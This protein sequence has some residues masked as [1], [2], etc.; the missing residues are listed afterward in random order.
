VQNLAPVDDRLEYVLRAFSWRILAHTP[1]WDFE[2]VRGS[3]SSYDDWCAAWRRQ[4]AHHEAL[5]DEAAR[6]GRRLTAGEAYLRAALMCH[7][8]SFLFPHDQEQFGAALAEMERA[9]R[10]AAPTVDPP[11]ELVEVELD[12]VP[13]PG[14]LRLPHGVEPPALAVLVPG[15]DSTKKEFYAFGEEIVRRGIAV[16]GFDGPGHGAVSLRLKMR[17]DFERVIS[18]VLDFLFARGGFDASRVAVGG[19]SYGG[20]FSLRAAADDARVAA[21]FSVGSWYSPAG[22][23]ANGHPVSQ[24]GVRQYMGDDPPGV[25]DRITLA[26]WTERIAVPV[27]QLYGGQDRLSPPEEAYRIDAEL[28]CPSTLVVLDEAVHM[29]NNVPYRARAAVADWLA[30][31]LGA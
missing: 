30:E 17:P 11:M 26:G 22:R 9:W 27:L 4:A 6:A 12:G 5:G 8:A 15:G 7:W 24:A 31:T 1:P 21:A 29:G 18:H 28:G 16:F 2:Q 25:Q 10:K 14:Y 3:L 19:F 23:Y 13:L 20:L